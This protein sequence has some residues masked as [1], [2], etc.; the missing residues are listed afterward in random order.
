MQGMRP[1]LDGAHLHVAVERGPGAGPG[2][3]GVLVVIAPLRLGLQGGAGNTGRGHLRWWQFAAP[4]SASTFVLR[5]LVRSF[6]GVTGP[7]DP[8]SPPRPAGRGLFPVI[9]RLRPA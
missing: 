4:R 2:L 1:R 9:G 6:L 5:E 7:R 8:P 3:A